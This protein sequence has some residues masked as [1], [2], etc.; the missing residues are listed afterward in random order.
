MHRQEPRLWRFTLGTREAS[1]G[2]GVVA[3]TSVTFNFMWWPQRQARSTRAEQNPHQRKS[4]T[5]MVMLRCNALHVFPR[6]TPCRLLFGLQ[7]ACRFPIVN[8]REILGTNSFSER[9]LENA[10]FNLIQTT[11]I[12]RFGSR[13]ADKKCVCVCV[14]VWNVCLVRVG[15]LSVLRERVCE[16]EREEGEGEKERDVVCCCMGSCTPSRAKSFDVFWC[17]I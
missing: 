6:I 7:H 4:T 13:N 5:Q 1:I 8:V 2:D 15:A 11:D 14:W 9:R 16:E 10:V 3:N 17:A 12:G